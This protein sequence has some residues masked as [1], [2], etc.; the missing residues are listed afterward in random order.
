MSEAR[1][2][3]KTNEE[4]AQLAQQYGWQF[5]PDAPEFVDAWRV[6]PFTEN[7]DQRLAFGVV[8]GQFNGIP[9]LTFDFHRRPKVTHYR[10]AWT[11]RELSSLDTI[12]I[13]TVWAMKLPAQLPFF[14]IASSIEPA[15]EVDAYPEPQTPDPKFNRWYKLIGTDPNVAAYFLHPQLMQFMREVKLHTW[16]VVGDDLL[17]MEHPIFGRTK[18]D[19][20]LE[21]LGK[22]QQLVGMLPFQV[23]R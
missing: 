4:R 2:I 22:L 10:D 7:G 12:V 21:T 5:R 14:Q 16:A 8:T 11:D 20:I 17:F 1:R 9:F 13:D 3:A 6:L 19:E 15:F 18:P 23:W